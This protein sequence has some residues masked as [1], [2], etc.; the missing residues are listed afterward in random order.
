MTSSSRTSTPPSSGTLVLAST[1]AYNPR[2]DAYQTIDPMG[3]IDQQ[4]FDDAGR[5]TQ[6]VQN[7]VSGGTAADQN[8]TVQTAYTP[9]GLIATL[10]A[11][12]PTT[13]N[14]VTQYA[15]GTSAGT[16]DSGVARTDLL[17]AMIYPD[18]A[19]SFAMSNGT[20][21]FSN[22][23]GT[24]GV[25]NRVEYSYNPLGE[26]VTLM[27]QNQTVHAY[28][29]DGLGR[30]STDSIVVTGSGVN[31]SVLQIARSY[32]VRGMLQHVTRGSGTEGVVN[33]VLMVYNNF[34]QLSG[35]Y[36]EHSGPTLA[37]TA[38]R[39]VQYAYSSGTANTIRLTGVTYPSGSR[40]ITFGYNS[41]DDDNLS[42]VSYLG[43]SGT[44]SQFK[45]LGLGQ[46]VTETYPQPGVTLDYSGG[47]SASYAGLDN[48]GRVAQQ[49]WLSTSGTT[50]DQFNYT[51][52]YAGNRLYRKNMVAGAGGALDELYNYDHVYRL[53]QSRA[54]RAEHIGHGHFRHGRT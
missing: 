19:N 37:T 23:S 22:G 30:P 2:G 47:T 9:D 44:L 25:Y 12:N 34:G 42:R 24:A 13:G 4:V 33:D 15:Y 43:S 32:E 11:V 14:Q 5:P 41:G 20:P 1:S 26:R 7:L 46:I 48:F 45:Y 38:S 35:E 29:F 50:L 21:T 8:V 54:R 27:D 49:P 52:D 36:Q 10:T 17:K 3:R 53:G 28:Q 31:S 6:S 16:A 39:S 18:S 40:S 51:Y